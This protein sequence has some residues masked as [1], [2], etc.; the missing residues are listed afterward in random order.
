M[1]HYKLVI[2]NG[3]IS[4]EIS[5]HEKE[6]VE[7]KE[8]EYIDIFKKTSGQKQ[9]SRQTSET[10][11]KER[12]SLEKKYYTKTPVNE[13]YRK[14]I[15]GQKLSRPDIA[16]F[17]VYYLTKVQNEESVKASDVKQLFKKIQ[18]PSWNTLNLPDILNKAKR[19]AF[20]NSV[21]NYWTLTITGEDFVLNTLSS[22]DK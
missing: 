5:S 10:T 11:S 4:V 16:T 21:G 22:S 13:F 9:I 2:T 1:E 7:K 19:K 3:D 12:T 8:K 17:F 20:L 6:W 18:Y 14:F 15:H